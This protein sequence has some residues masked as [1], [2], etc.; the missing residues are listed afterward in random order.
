MASFLKH[1]SVTNIQSCNQRAEHSLAISVMN[2]S[3]MGEQQLKIVHA[4]VVQK[5][6][7]AM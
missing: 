6:E 4:N 2:P 7:L 3:E 5:T 1:A